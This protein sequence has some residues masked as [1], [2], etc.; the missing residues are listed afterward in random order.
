[1]PD[2][3]A[4]LRRLDSLSARALELTILATA[5]TGEVIGAKWTEFD[6]REQ[7]WTL[8]AE[9]MKMKAQHKVPLCNRAV[10]LLECLPRH[11]DRVFQLSDMAMLQCL[12]GLRPGLTVHGFRSTFMDWAHEQTAT[13]KVVIDMAL[14]HAV[15]DKVEAAYRRGDL[16]EKRAR[17]MALW[18][19]YCERPARS[20]TVTPMRRIDHA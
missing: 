14:A 3:M 10:A 12:R 8:P 17:L 7:T 2:F 4:A 9:R 20:A 6:L 15:G 19:D 11:G 18:A 5:R 1:M 16:F 13:A